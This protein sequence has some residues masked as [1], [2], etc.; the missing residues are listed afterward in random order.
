MGIVQ[1]LPA[2]L[3]NMIAAG[4]VVQRPSSVVKELL[5]N[6][7]DAGAKQIGLIIKDAGRTLIQ[8]IDDGCGMSADDALTCF[9]RH[10]TSK[11]KSQ[12]DLEKILTF[13][14]RGEALASIA[15]VAQITLKTRREEDEVGSEVIIEAGEVK[16]QHSVS[17]PKGTSIEVRNLFYNT[18]ARRKFLKSD[19]VE[20]KHIIEEFTRVAI[21]RPDLSFSISHNG[22]DVL[23]LKKVQGLKFRIL[24][25]LGSGV[26]GD[27]VD[28]NFSTSLISI[29]GYIG[30]PES[31]K[32]SLGNQYLFVN[33]R[34]FRSAYFHKA[35]MNAYA[36]MTPEGMTPSYILFLEVDPESVDVNISPT[37]TEVKF[38]EDSAIFQSIYACVRETLGRNSF[39]ASLDFETEGAINIPQLGKSFAAYKPSAIAPS[40]D[41]DS[42]YNPFQS[43]DAQSSPF[44]GSPS[45]SYGALFEQTALPSQQTLTIG[46]KY[47]LTPVEGGLMAVNLFRA[48]TRI[49]YERML[50]V[51]GGSDHFSQMSMFPVEVQI[52]AANM[53]I[54]EDN[55]EL[56]TDLGFGI[57]PF[58]V[59]SISVSALPE[60]YS[61]DEVSVR[62]CVA[63]LLQILDEGTRQ[64]PQV[65][66][67]NLARRFAEL[68]AARYGIPKTTFEAA[69]LLDELFSCENTELTP[70]GKRI[71]VIIPSGSSTVATM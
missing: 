63:E 40:V 33:G 18:P 10:A 44:H 8:V 41:F 66:Q 54:I 17:Q 64:L 65:M 59:D 68:G 21:T 5:E 53:P 42:S 60:G 20:F 71:S 55:L 48:R 35:V 12:E 46:G 2:R 67:S 26:V 29:N 34:F 43:S 22:K 19:N 47:L 27:V 38:A 4:E 11:I 7:V 30:R 16:E 13:G 62:E 69:R 32:K 56:L 24:D 39:G 45:Q 51:L 23:V 36:E 49:L 58:G 25:L 14:F 31:A 1:V 50:K 70:S 37:K 28:L 52:G 9:Q 6:A 3:S 15:S 61:S 57:A